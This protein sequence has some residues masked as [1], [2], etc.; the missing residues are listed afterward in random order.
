MV[1]LDLET[2]EDHLEIRELYIYKALFTV[3]SVRCGYNARWSM[4]VAIAAVGRQSSAGVS[5]SGRILPS[6]GVRSV[7]VAFVCCARLS[8]GRSP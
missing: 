5:V 7:Q 8:G 3:R 1:R 2:A 4:V 6:K